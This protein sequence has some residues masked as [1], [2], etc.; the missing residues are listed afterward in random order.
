MKENNEYEP[1]LI[2]ALL[3]QLTMNSVFYDVG[4]EFGY[5]SSAVHTAGLAKNDI[6]AFEPH[7]YNYSILRQNIS[8]FASVHRAIVANSNNWGKTTLSDQADNN[9]TPDVIKIDT[10]GSEME[11]LIGSKALLQD[12]HP[13]IFIEVH[14]QFINNTGYSVDDLVDF[15]QNIGYTL[16]IVDHRLKNSV[17]TSA[18]RKINNSS[19]PSDREFLVWAT[20]N[21]QDITQ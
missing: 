11:V 7:A 1:G 6:H 18:W 13:E 19:T 10:E 4:A 5:I 16:K 3:D 8:S 21:R 20:Q 14:P 2:S 17:E 15:L 12:N 9:T